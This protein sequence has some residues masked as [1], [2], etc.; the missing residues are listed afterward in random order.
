MS[1]KLVTSLRKSGDIAS[2]LEM[3][4]N[5]YAASKDQYSA[6]ALFWTLK[7]VCENK[8]EGGDFVAANEILVEIRDAFANMDDDLGIGKR[9]LGQLETNVC[10]EYAE[11]LRLYSLAKTGD[12]EE[13]F[14]KVC[15]IQDFSSFSETV[16]DYASW[17]VFY[18]LKI[19]LGSVSKEDFDEAVE[20]YYAIDGAKPSLVH[21][22]ILNMAIKFTGLHQDYDLIGFIRRWDVRNFRAEDCVRDPNFANGLSL[23]DRAARRCFA[24][25]TVTLD[26]VKEVFKDSP[27]LTGKE[28][29]ELLSRS[30]SF[31]LYKDSVDN[32]G[33]QVFSA[34]AM[35]YVNR[36]GESNVICNQSHS[37]VLESV[38]WEVDGDR[39]SWFKDY[40]EKWGFGESLRPEDWRKQEGKDGVKLPSL[41]EKALGRYAEAV[42]KYGVGEN[43][44]RYKSLL[45]CASEKLTENESALRHLAKIH[46]AEGDAGT[47]AKIICDLIR[48]HSVKFYYWSDLASYLPS[49][50]NNLAAAC[51]ARAIMSCNDERYLGKIHLN[52]GRCLLRM[53]MFGEALCEAEK[54]KA[55]CERN[56]WPVRCGYNEIVAAV[57]QGTVAAKGN[58]GIYSKLEKAIDEYVYS[59]LPKY[60]MVYISKIAQ[61]NKAGGKKRQ[62][63]VLYDSENTRYLINPNA[64]GLSG[65]ADKYS[66]FEVR[67]VSEGKNRRKVVS[68]KPTARV[69]VLTY[70]PGVVIRLGDGGVIDTVLGD[71]FR[72]NIHHSDASVVG[73]VGQNVE[74]AMN[75]RVVDGKTINSFID[76]RMSD[77]QI[78]IADAFNGKLRIIN[79]NSKVFGFVDSIYIGK[80]LVDG[81]RNGESVSGVSVSDGGRTY[82]ITLRHCSED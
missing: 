50:G 41:A 14:T 16:K 44:E 74:V 38:V 37:K 66:C 51:Y 11:I 35:E 53:N 22:Q 60:T 48:T 45:V 63:F 2:A 81:F 58:T 69:D 64:F 20:K 75:K 73:F 49:S 15:S 57:P 1:F 12:V 80:H 21:S 82:A 67:Y 33:W 31:L 47:A 24:N 30:Y 52:L 40:F 36:I 77:R 29:E 70:R 43:S 71:G 68:V 78:N 32:K 59:D 19:R 54:Y 65:K 76:L 9:C 17:I 7:V 3:A 27:E 26:E 34:D 62:M 42:D 23:R 39:L 72:V 56:G 25:R 28:I 13:A 10:P 61:V 18:Y 8:I 46:F 55:T 4:R 6:S 79:K 5:D